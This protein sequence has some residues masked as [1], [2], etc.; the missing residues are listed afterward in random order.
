[1]ARRTVG[2]AAGRATRRRW[3]RAACVRRRD[4]RATERR[5]A[6]AGGGGGVAP[7]GDP[8]SEDGPQ[9]ES[10]ERQLLLRR[11]SQKC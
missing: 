6:R 3:C 5:D 2:P 9:P 4:S 11:S 1:M 8:E 7:V 10:K